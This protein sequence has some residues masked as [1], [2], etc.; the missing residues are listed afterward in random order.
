MGTFITMKFMF[1]AVTAAFAVLCMS[2]VH[3]TSAI[4]RQPYGVVPLAPG[5]GPRFSDELATMSLPELYKQQQKTLRAKMQYT[6]EGGRAGMHNV[7]WAQLTLR[8][9][10]TRKAINAKYHA[11]DAVR[12]SQ[13]KKNLLGELN[14]KIAAG[15]QRQTDGPWYAKGCTNCNET[16]K[17]KGS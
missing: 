8:E 17:V 14:Q 6:R 4:T 2:P 3:A 7:G 16:G 15:K 9:R 12:Y 1:Y 10:E 5:F 13:N 11:A